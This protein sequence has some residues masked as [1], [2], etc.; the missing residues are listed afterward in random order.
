MFFPRRSHTRPAPRR[1]PTFDLLE[2]RLV[3]AT[4]LVT[5]TLD[6]VDANDGKLSLR[7]AINAAN[8]SPGA[9]TILVPA[10]VYHLALP[11][12]DD[13]N[14]AGDFDVTGST[15]FQGA[16][17][18]ATVIDGQ[19]LDRVF[20]VRG[21]DPSSISVTFQGLT[22]RNGLADDGGGGGIRVGDADL[23]V[24][25]CAIT[26]NRT[27][28]FGGGIS[29]AA[30][31]ATGNVT[32]V[33]STVTRNVAG[34]GGGVVVLDTPADPQFVLTVR[35]STIEHNLATAAGGIFA[36]KVNLTGSTVSGNQASVNNGGGIFTNTATLTNCTV[37]GNSGFIG[38]GIEA[39]TAMLTGCTVSGNVAAADGGGLEVGTLTL[40]STAVS[41][42]QATAGTGGGI[43]AVTAT[44]TGSTVTDNFAGGNGGGISA[45][46]M[47][48]L[49]NSTVTDN[50]AGGNGGGIFSNG[51]AT[52]TGSSVSNNFTTK[53]GGGVEADTANL[54]DSTVAGNV[55][56]GGGGIHA[57]TVELTHSTITGN[58]AND[59]GGGLSVEDAT[60]TDSTVSDNSAFDTAGGIFVGGTATLT[61][62]TVSG[63]SAG[64]DGGGLW[65]FTANLTDSTV[66]GN[67]AGRNGGGIEVGVLTLLSAT[68]TENSAHAGGGV[69]LSKGATARLRNTI[70]AQ[71][72]V[73]LT[74]TGPDV[75]GAFAGGDRILIGDSSGSTGLVNGENG[76]QVGTAADPIDARLG[77]LADNGG[78]TL[79]HAL[80]PGSPA[81]DR[82]DNI[83]LP[84]TDQRGAGFPHVAGSGPDI[85]AFEVQPPPLAAPDPPAPG[86]ARAVFVTFL[87]VRAGKKVRLLVVE[88]FAD[89][90]AVKAVF[91]APFQPD[92]FKAISVTPLDVNGDGAADLLF[93]SAVR[94]GRTQ[95]ALLLA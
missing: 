91:A 60:L 6:V 92:K 85:G 83:E 37:S 32:L 11:G 67:H 80:L 73:D 46:V 23:T 54:A 13:T 9:D 43:D 29:N 39:D 36:V 64:G 55:A 82:G 12:A 89:T 24:Q 72:L 75:S 49:L 25:D 42:N 40:T 57:T 47:A 63:N 33:R 52:L 2:D 66:S 21:T 84:A 71:N 48:T 19:R 15:V 7:E 87:K 94:K 59:S 35:D 20:D 50:A 34:Q 86:P 1:R 53:A 27:T 70:I 88:R 78:P 74:G 76:D 62:S 22:V 45:V 81:I 79:T 69:F 65:G 44:L 10:G 17:A 51:A 28:G 68:V 4:F 61:R 56:G 95:F 38:G 5:T 14:A 26:D 31:A 30:L 77:P 8:A 16:G 90:G 41:G 58:R 18:G 93:F 3:P